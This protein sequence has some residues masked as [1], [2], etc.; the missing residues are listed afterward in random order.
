MTA[1]L[2]DRIVFPTVADKKTYHF[3]T[4][5]KLPHERVN[6]NIDAQGNIRAAYGENSLNILLGYINDERNRIELTLRQIDDDP[7]HFIQ[8]VHYNSDG[9]VNNDWLEPSKRIKNYHTANKFKDADGVTRKIEGNGTRFISF[10]GIYTDKGFIS[11][12]DP[13]KTS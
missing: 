9:T 7:S 10:S 3:I 11:F 6:Y 2:S 5:I 12:N 13:K 4:G 8:G 1:I